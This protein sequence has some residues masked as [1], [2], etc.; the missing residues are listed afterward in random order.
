MSSMIWPRFSMAEAYEDAD[1]TP[2]PLRI[3]KRG[4]KTMPD[5]GASEESMSVPVSDMAGKVKLQASI[6]T[7]EEASGAEQPLLPGGLAKQPK[8]PTQPTQPTR[9]F[10]AKVSPPPQADTCNIHALH[11]PKQRRTNAKIIPDRASSVLGSIGRV[12]SSPPGRPRARQFHD[13]TPDLMRQG[14]TSG[15]ATHF[16]VLASARAVTTSAIDSQHLPRRC[17]DGTL[18]PAA[19]SQFPHDK[20]SRAVTVDMVDGDVQAAHSRHLPPLRSSCTQPSLRQRLFSRVMSGVSSRSHISHAA[21]ERE[22]VIRQLHSTTSE[23]TEPLKDAPSGRAR[24]GSIETISTLGVDL[25]Q[26]LAAFP[27]PPVSTVTS[28]TTISSFE[29]SRTASGP[30]R[31][32]V[33]PTNV[34]TAGAELGLLSETT[35]L[36]LDSGQSV[37]V[38]VEVTGNVNPMDKTCDAPS[39]P[40]GL[41]VAVIIDGT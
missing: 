17:L 40:K 28:P 34:A 14:T 36:S 10:T 6:G 23:R 19:A 11:V 29:T 18:L 3:I 7:R 26:A 37:F 30:S 12:T 33:Q 22:A 21:T 13:L 39:Q 32:L 41:D 27:T 4:N 8:Q 20:R 25:E 16:P 1:A 5:S 9:R 15:G 24:S 2:R 31:K 38:A 35:E